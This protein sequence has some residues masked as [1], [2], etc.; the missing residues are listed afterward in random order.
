MVRRHA[1]I[2]IF[3][4]GKMPGI[5]PEFETL[6]MGWAVSGTCGDVTADEIAGKEIKMQGMEERVL[7]V[8]ASRWELQDDKTNEKR[9]GTSIWC[10]PEDISPYIEEDLSLTGYVPT[11]FSTDYEFFNNVIKAGGAPVVATL[12]YI[13]RTRQNKP[14]LVLKSVQLDSD[15]E[16]DAEEEDV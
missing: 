12:N 11:K 7:I 4:F 14:T 8:S 2:P 9:R 5:F 3:P 10:I 1:I 6:P 13:I 15:T 16:Y